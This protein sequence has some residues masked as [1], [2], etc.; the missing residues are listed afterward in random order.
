MNTV[1]TISDKEKKYLFSIEMRPESGPYLIN[2]NNEIVL[3]GDRELT[4]VH[5]V[6]IKTITRKAIIPKSVTAQRVKYKTRV[7]RFS[8][9]PTYQNIAGLTMRDIRFSLIVDEVFRKRFLPRSSTPTIYESGI[10]SLICPTSDE[11]YDRSSGPEALFQFVFC[12]CCGAP[13]PLV[14]C[15]RDRRRI[16]AL[17]IINS[18]PAGRTWRNP[19]L[20]VK[21][22]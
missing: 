9:V 16:K 19:N 1:K 17:R 18:Q 22:V 21:D 3:K 5:T 8:P 2:E 6:E 14:K 4:D 11:E 15:K 13:H 10:K 12:G 20:T 7:S